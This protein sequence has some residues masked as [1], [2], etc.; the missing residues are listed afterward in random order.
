[1]VLAGPLHGT[2]EPGSESKRS[3]TF[4]LAELSGRHLGIVSEVSRKC[5]GSLARHLLEELGDD[6]AA[7]WV[8]AG[9][10]LALRRASEV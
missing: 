5:L 3:L 9:C 4:L 10:A 2:C 6:V 8:A 1:M 7:L